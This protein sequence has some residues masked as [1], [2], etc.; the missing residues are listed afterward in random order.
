MAWMVS[1]YPEPPAER[2]HTCPVCG[3]DC[4]HIFVNSENE[5]CG[6]DQCGRWMF[7]DDFEEEESEWY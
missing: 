4:E 6:C 1:D 3:E 7:I 2:R 5:V